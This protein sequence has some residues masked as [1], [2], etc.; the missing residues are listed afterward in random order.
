MKFQLGDRVRCMN[1]TDF[2]GHEGKIVAISR[3][4]HDPYPYTIQWDNGPWGS[5]RWEQGGNWNGNSLEQ[6]GPSINIIEDWRL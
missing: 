4:P 3:F 1:G 2:H 6:A 5:S